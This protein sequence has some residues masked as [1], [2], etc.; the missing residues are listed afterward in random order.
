MHYLATWHRDISQ[1]SPSHPRPQT[2]WRS[3]FLSSAP[4]ERVLRC[5]LYV[6]S[7]T[8]QGTHCN[9]LCSHTI[10]STTHAPIDGG[11]GLPRSEGEGHLSNHTIHST[12]ARAV[13]FSVVSCVCVCYSWI[14]NKT[15]AISLC[16][17]FSESSALL[18]PAL[19]CNRAGRRP[20][21]RFRGELH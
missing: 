11:S 12:V 7:S 1:S 3:L 14:L 13:Y 4:I 19:L 9:Q 15:S 17:F 18:P 8:L 10:S 5:N 2:A 6:P 20:V 16:L 21:T